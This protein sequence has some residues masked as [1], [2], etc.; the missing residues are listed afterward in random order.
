MTVTDT[1]TFANGGGIFRSGDLAAQHILTGGTMTAG[2]SGPATL[3]LRQ[4]TSAAPDPGIG[5]PEALN[6]L[7]Q[8]TD[9][10]GGGAVTVVKSG[11]GVTRWSAAAG[12]TFTGGLYVN[13]GQLRPTTAGALGAAISPVYVAD[14]A[15]VLVNTV[16]KIDNPWFIKGHGPQEQGGVVGGEFRGGAIRLNNAGTEIAGTVTLQSDASIGARRWS[17]QFS[18]HQRPVYQRQNYRTVSVCD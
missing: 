7:T 10:A 3:Y 8:I 15:Q 5:P 11:F 18:G 6:I 17:D 14:R 9:N 2:T 4:R 12:N 1:L 13:E 16:S